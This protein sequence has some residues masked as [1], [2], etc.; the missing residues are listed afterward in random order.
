MWGAHKADGRIAANNAPKIRGALRQSVDAEELWRGYQETHPIATEHPALD[1]TRARAWAMLHIKFDNESLFQVLK[2]VWADGF[3]LGQA[4]ANEAIG[5]AKLAK[6]APSGDINWDAWKPGNASASLLLKPTG[7]FQLILDGA[8][9][10]IKGLNKS[11]INDIGTALA[12]SVSLG[13][14][15]KKAS[16]LISSVISDPARALS[17][18]ITEQSRAINLATKERYTD[19]GLEEMEWITSDPCPICIQNGGQ[20]VRIGQAF[21]SGDEEPPA[22]PNC[23]CALLPVI[24]EFEPNANGVVDIA[25]QTPK[26]VSLSKPNEL[27]DLMTYQRRQDFWSKTV[28]SEQDDALFSYTSN[29]YLNM[30]SVARTGEVGLGSTS[31]E[32]LARIVKANDDLASLISSAPP[33]SSDL[34]TY[35]GVQGNIAKAYLTAKPGDIIKDKGFSSTS[36]LREKAEIYIDTP[37]PGSIAVSENKA[38]LEIVNPA[39]TR[40]IMVDGFQNDIIPSDKIITEPLTTAFSTR[41][42]YEWLLNG[43]TSFEVVSV[44][45]FTVRVRVK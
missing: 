43:N 41:T 40:G 19:A 18:A 10:T 12:D 28:P 8:G 27:H 1:R 4:S 45:G 29:S 37:L 25:P 17:I 21:N 33:L 3:V 13:Y 14:S 32:H 11:S 23:R 42:Q 30:Q 22:H 44:N 26:P 5:K 9:I 24:P 7:A 38:I 35:R 6:K 34:V 16:K 2:K 15:S 36:L 39:G 20:K 31:P